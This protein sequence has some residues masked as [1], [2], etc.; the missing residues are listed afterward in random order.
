M[1]KSKVKPILKLVRKGD[2]LA[3]PKGPHTCL[4]D[5]LM[6]VYLYSDRSFMKLPMDAKDKS[7]RV[8]Q[9]AIN[10]LSSVDCFCIHTGAFFPR[11]FYEGRWTA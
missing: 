10:M 6:D 9:V 2:A 7:N 1:R 5:L 3:N 11:I 4:I 8:P